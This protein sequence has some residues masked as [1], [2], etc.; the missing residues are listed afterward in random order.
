MKMKPLFAGIFFCM[1]LGTFAST[2]F[3]IGDSL[4][5]DVTVSKDIIGSSYNCF[6]FS[7]RLHTNTWLKTGLIFNGTS[8]RTEYNT[9]QAY[10][11]SDLKLTAGFIFGF[12]KHSCKFAEGIEFI[13]G[14]HIRFLY[15]MDKAHTDNPTL[16]VSLQTTITNEFRTGIGFTFGLYYHFSKSFAIGSEINPNI[17]YLYSKDDE[18]YYGSKITGTEYNIF[19]NLALVSLKYMW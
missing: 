8:N 14:Y 4:R 10:P 13:Y 3:S 6:R 2:G 1:C 11:T 7:H 19:T 9:A 5:N 18:D 12:D 16:P 17:V 15:T